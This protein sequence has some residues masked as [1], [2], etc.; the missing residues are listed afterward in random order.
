M[1]AV[2]LYTQNRNTPV[3]VLPEPHKRHLLQC[4]K[5]TQDLDESLDLNKVTPSELE[6]VLSV[7]YVD[8]NRDL[9]KVE[10]IGSGERYVLHDRAVMQPLLDALEKGDFELAEALTP[11]KERLCGYTELKETTRMEEYGLGWAGQY[12]ITMVPPGIYPIFVSK[13]AYHERDK[14]YTNEVHYM[15]ISKWFEGTCIE[16]DI[17]KP[18]SQEPH[19]VF[20]SPYAYDVARNISAGTGPSRLIYPFETA[21]ATHVSVVDGKTFVHFTIVDSSVPYNAP[22]NPL[23]LRFRCRPQEAGKTSLADKL[24]QAEATKSQKASAPAAPTKTNEQPHR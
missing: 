13:F 17:L 20:R 8:R 10:P 15:G 14:H 2:T 24:R 4:L 11:I 9:S 21:S 6:S 22:E 19:I 18:G 16:S 23:H 3:S 5:D 12:A 7:N 1:K